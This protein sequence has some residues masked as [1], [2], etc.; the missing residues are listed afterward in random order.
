MPGAYYYESRESDAGKLAKS[1]DA[2]Q[3]FDGKGVKLPPHG[4]D[5]GEWKRSGMR[6]VGE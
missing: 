2:T 6:T 3:R 1:I 4:V 5:V